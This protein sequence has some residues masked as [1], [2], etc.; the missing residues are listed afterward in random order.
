D[1]YGNKYLLD[2]PDEQELAS[3]MIASIDN[4]LKAPSVPYSTKVIDAYLLSVFAGSKVM[5]E[6]LRTKAFELALRTLPDTDTWNDMWRASLYSYNKLRDVAAGTRKDLSALRQT[7]ATEPFHEKV[8]AV[9][10]AGDLMNKDA[11]LWLTEL[12]D[13][14]KSSNLDRN[15]MGIVADTL[16]FMSKRG[17]GRDVSLLKKLGTV[18]D[19]EKNAMSTGVNV[20]EKVRAIIRLALIGNADSDAALLRLLRYWGGQWNTGIGPTIFSIH[21]ALQKAIFHRAGFI[22]ENP[23]TRAYIDTQKQVLYRNTPATAG[24]T[25]AYIFASGTFLSLEAV[26]GYMGILLKTLTDAESPLEW[27]SAH[28]SIAAMARAGV[29]MNAVDINNAIIDGWKSILNKE[30]E[31]NESELKVLLGTY[32]IGDDGMSVQLAAGDK[33]RIETLQRRIARLRESLAGLGGASSLRGDEAIAEATKR[34]QSATAGNAEEIASSAAS[35]GLLA[36]TGGAAA[37]VLALTGENVKAV[38][39]TLLVL[40]SNEPSPPDEKDKEPAPSDK[41][42]KPEKKLVEVGEMLLVERLANGNILTH[43]SDYAVRLWRANGEFIKHIS[44]EDGKISKVGF[45]SVGVIHNGTKFITLCEGQARL[46]DA[47]GNFNKEEKSENMRDCIHKKLDNGKF[48]TETKWG[49]LVMR[50]EN[51]APITEAFNVKGV[52]VGTDRGSAHRGPKY[53]KDSRVVTPDSDH[54]VRIWD[55]EGKNPVLF[56]HESAGLFSCD[57]IAERY[58]ESLAD[59]RIVTVDSDIKVRIWGADG[60]FIS[61]LEVDTPCNIAFSS[62]GPDIKV[63]DDGTFITGDSDKC[64]R[65]WN[66]SGENI[67]VMSLEGDANFGMVQILSGSRILVR[68]QGDIFR[69]D[70]YKVKVF[71][72]TNKNIITLTIPQAKVGAHSAFPLAG[73]RFITH[74]DDEKYRV[75]NDQGNVIS[76]LSYNGTEIVSKE[77]PQ[78]IDNIIFLR[79]GTKRLVFNCAGEFLLELALPPDE[80]GKVPALSGRWV[81]KVGDNLFCVAD[82]DGNMHGWQFELKVDPAIEAAKTSATKASDKRHLSAVALA[83]AEATSDKEGDKPVTTGVPP[84]EPAPGDNAKTNVPAGK[85]IARKVLKAILLGDGETFTE[86]VSDG[87]SFEEIMIKRNPLARKIDNELINE[88]ISRLKLGDIV[89]YKGASGKYDIAKLKRGPERVGKGFV[90]WLEC[91]RKIENNKLVVIT[92]DVSTDITPL[93]LIADSAEEKEIYDGYFGE[94]LTAIKLKDNAKA[95][96]IAGGKRFWR[97]AKEIHKPYSKDGSTG[98]FYKDLDTDDIVC[99]EDTP[100]GDMYIARIITAGEKTLKVKV[101]AEVKKANNFQITILDPEIVRSITKDS[102][103]RMIRGFDAEGALDR[104]VMRRLVMRDSEA[105]KKLSDQVWRLIAARKTSV[106]SEPLPDR[107][108][109]VFTENKKTGYIFGEVVGDSPGQGER[110][111]VEFAILDAKGIVFYDVP[112]ITKWSGEIHTLA[113]NSEITEVLASVPEKDIPVYPEPIAG[114]L[115]KKLVEILS[116]EPVSFDPLNTSTFDMLKALITNIADKPEGVGDIAALNNTDGSIDFL[117]L[118]GKTSAWTGKMKIEFE[119]LCRITKNGIERFSAR[120]TSVM[121]PDNMHKVLTADEYEK[122]VWKAL[123]ESIAGKDSGR[124]KMVVEGGSLVI[125]FV[126]N[127]TSIGQ[128]EEGGVTVFVDIEPGDIVMAYLEDGAA[129]YTIGEVI[130]I[131]DG[132][133]MLSDI[134]I[135][136]DKVADINVAGNGQKSEHDVYKLFCTIMKKDEYEGLT[137]SGGKRAQMRALRAEY[138]GAILKEDTTLAGKASAKIIETLFGGDSGKATIDGIMRYSSEK[139]DPGER[140]T[141]RPEKL[142][143]GDI[144]AKDR[145]NGQWRIARI[146]LPAATSTGENLVQ[147]ICAVNSSGAT[148]FKPT[149]PAKHVK[150]PIQD[151][152]RLLPAAEAAYLKYKPITSDQRL[153]TN[154]KNAAPAP[155]VGYERVMYGGEKKPEAV[156]GLDERSVRCSKDGKIILAYVDNKYRLFSALD[157]TFLKTQFNSDG[158]EQVEVIGGEYILATMVRRFGGTRGEEPCAIYGFDGNIIRDE[159]R[160]DEGRAT[161]GDFKVLSGGNILFH[162]LLGKKDNER[163][164][165]AH[166]FSPEGKLIECDMNLKRIDELKGVV[167]GSK[168]AMV[169]ENGEIVTSDSDGETRV[170]SADGGFLDV[171]VPADLKGVTIKIVTTEITPSGSNYFT[172]THSDGVKRMWERTSANE[173]IFICTIDNPNGEYYPM[174]GG[175]AAVKGSGFVRIQERGKTDIILR[176][177]KSSSV[178]GERN[179]IV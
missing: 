88:G 119:L 55:K 37:G 137:M 102:C 61:K 98:Y 73:D 27:P 72:K 158:I 53:L 170:W 91:I 50:D 90:V 43:D 58:G 39:S 81:R 85:N 103:Y 152:Y 125:D 145:G 1:I 95:D 140:F 142:E 108:N 175:R 174:P 2:T 87:A 129:I 28:R 14:A 150:W 157:G 97:L 89:I 166:L 113:D 165:E 75:W 12:L 10:Y 17:L 139:V 151:T 121:S 54:K 130:G 146:Q 71:D 127:H 23:V 171:L 66:S 163:I 33:I 7:F 124:A 117:R 16:Y 77:Q 62:S 80:T 164:K 105:L 6:L 9:L 56:D 29:S 118:T 78:V 32:G 69:K 159:I 45:W 149:T 44:D 31:A 60:K 148:I 168:D 84:A 100:D 30:L 143:K 162:S 178:I 52:N 38:H 26:S 4:D 25:P 173:T 179:V 138:L 65:R 11:F 46:W 132:K 74:D 63:L 93:Y 120:K 42:G 126:R 107:G 161:S 128:A 172:T 3:R 51:F 154:D 13:P 112:V 131:K 96:A 8:R 114:F 20:T 111:V 48:I 21:E 19:N 169:L 83:K 141:L 40:P 22:R 41:D 156:G 70:S 68:D 134:F 160:D 153:T 76:T 18:E 92:E 94:L 57:G 155:F 82:S 109:F 59:G 136:R 49:E 106:L 110:Y 5:D 144:V 135:C 122:I 133:V 176:I 67:G 36:T 24:T 104:E 147:V 86:Y 99:W 167:V 123:K 15:L 115:D 79:H 116:G 34:S 47:D 177:P 35:G 101:F 64:I